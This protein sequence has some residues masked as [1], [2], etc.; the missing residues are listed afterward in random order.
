MLS[1]N[2]PAF[3][4]TIVIFLGLIAYL[5]VKLYRPLLAFMDKREQSIADDEQKA[6]AND[7]DVGKAQSE[8]DEIIATARA[9][10]GKIKEQATA[11]AKQS[12]SEAIASKQSELEGEFG[13]YLASLSK[14]RSKLKSDLQKQIPEFKDGFKEALSKI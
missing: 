2:V 7:A 14:Q 5:N 12:A 6:V 1:I 4:A 8:I 11:E 10:A 13:E 3:I 9:E